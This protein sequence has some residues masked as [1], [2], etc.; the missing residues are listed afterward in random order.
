VIERLK[1]YFERLENLSAEELDRSAEVL[2]RA[3]KRNVQRFA[4]AC[5]SAPAI[6]VNTRRQTERAVPHEPASKLSTSG[7]LLCMA[8]TTRGISGFTVVRTIV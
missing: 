4:S 1:K 6:S 7:L 5:T 3:E 8:A 2:V